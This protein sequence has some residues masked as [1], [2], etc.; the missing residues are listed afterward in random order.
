MAKKIEKKVE[1]HAVAP[2][3][4]AEVVTP[5]VVNPVVMPDDKN[6]AAQITEDINNAEL[7]AFCRVRAGVGL[8]NI[9]E[10]NAHGEWEKRLL[11]L[12]PNRSKATLYRYMQDGRKFC[13]KVDLDAGRVYEKMI[14]RVNE[15]PYTAPDQDMLNIFCQGEILT[16]APEWNDA[17]HITQKTI[18]PYIRHYGGSNKWNEPAV[19]S[20][21]EK[22]EWRLKDA[23]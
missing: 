7:G 13:S 20:W 5:E 21:Y 15:A 14:R 12:F 3:K 17:G 8:C 22:Q 19:F 6:L 11:A 4:K 10:L 18:D 16:L 9:R 23:D 2:A 1:K